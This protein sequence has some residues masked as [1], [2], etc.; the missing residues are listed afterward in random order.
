MELDELCPRYKLAIGELR[1]FMRYI[2]HY[3]VII[4]F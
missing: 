4:M 1:I 3:I 2:I